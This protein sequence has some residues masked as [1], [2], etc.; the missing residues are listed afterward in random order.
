M[1]MPKRSLRFGMCRHV[2]EDARL[3]LHIYYSAKNARD[4]PRQNAIILPISRFWRAIALDLGS[5]T[6][7]T[8]ERAYY[9]GRV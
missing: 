7:K 6:G 3:F 1:K 4:V 9:R 5:E 8:V 2:I